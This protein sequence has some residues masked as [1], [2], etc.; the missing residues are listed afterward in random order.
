MD[1]FQPHKKT[2]YLDFEPMLTWRG[3]GPDARSFIAA[4]SPSLR[5]LDLVDQYEE[6]VK[7]SY[8]MQMVGFLTHY[9]KQIN[10]VRAL[11]QQWN[12]GLL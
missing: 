6:M 1:Q 10:E 9:A 11:I 2:L 12:Q 4:H 7:A 5:I 8:D 3:W